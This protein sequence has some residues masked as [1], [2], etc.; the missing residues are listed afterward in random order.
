[1][2]ESLYLTPESSVRL[3]RYLDQLEGELQSAKISGLKLQLI[4]FHLFDLVKDLP[5]SSSTR[6]HTEALLEIVEKKNS[7][8]DAARKGA[9][10][11]GRLREIYQDGKFSI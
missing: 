11:I 5:F 2:H 8:P 6:K 4:R 9:R 1:M 3:R 7:L 10:E